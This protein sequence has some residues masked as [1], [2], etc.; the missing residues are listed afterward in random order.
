MRYFKFKQFIIEKFLQ[1]TV[2]KVGYTL[3][4]QFPFK[5]ELLLLFDQNVLLPAIITVTSPL[6]L[7]LFFWESYFDEL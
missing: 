7:K 6:N 4:I 5:T 1:N 2:S 3:A